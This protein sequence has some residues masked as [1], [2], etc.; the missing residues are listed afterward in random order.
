MTVTLRNGSM[1]I[2][3]TE[4][5]TGLGGQELRIL[6]EARGLMERGHDVMLAVQPGSQLESEA[7]RIGLRVEPLKMT[8]VRW[9]SLIRDFIRLIRRYRPDILNT[10]NSID[11]WTASLAARMSR[12]RPKIIRT[13]HKSTPISKTVRHTVLYQQ[14]PDAIVTTSEMTREAMVRDNG[15]DPKKIVSIPT[16]VDSE[17]FCPCLPDPVFKASLGLEPDCAIVGTIAFLRDYKGVEDILEAAPRVMEE[18]PEVCFV[19]VGDGP[20]KD[21]LVQK[22]AT[23]GIA[24]RVHFLGFREDVATLLANFDVFVLAS[25]SGEGVPQ[26]LLQAMAMARP[27]VATRVGGIPE[28]VEDGA[29][30]FLVNP[31]N[32][33]DL[34]QKICRFLRE[35]DLR[36]GL[37]EKG[38]RI[39]VERYTLQSMLDK[40]E[41]LYRALAS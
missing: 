2:L 9:L 5:S 14:L 1:R 24:Q 29:S 41:S 30:G 38:R 25:R 6:H 16:G 28:V 33:S 40:T 23:L 12:F 3:H 31:L 15:V 26:A 4:S 7:V 39:V 13:R 35:P 27:V 18:W 20:E 36:S 19:I 11:S 21:H 34:A 8:W 22:S 17:T 32:A 37:G 10:H